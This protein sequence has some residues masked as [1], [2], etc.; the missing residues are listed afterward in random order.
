METKPK[1]KRIF[2]LLNLDGRNFDIVV[3]LERI[4]DQ[5]PRF[6]LVCRNG[7]LSDTQISVL[8]S[9][10]QSDLR[11]FLFVDGRDEDGLRIHSIENTVFHLEN[12]KFSLAQQV[13]GAPSTI[14]DLI[15]VYADV[16]TIINDESDNNP[17]KAHLKR[18]K[19][20]AQKIIGL[21]QVGSQKPEDIF[22]TFEK[23]CLQAYLEF[24][25]LKRGS[26]SSVP[27]KFE[28]NRPERRDRLAKLE[29]TYP[30]DKIV[31]ISQGMT[32][33][34]EKSVRE[35]FRKRLLTE[36]VASYV[37]EHCAPIWRNAV[38]EAKLLLT[39]T[40]FRVDGR[41]A[42][43]VDPRTFAGFLA[44]NGVSFEAT[45]I[46]KSSIPP[47]RG[48]NEWNC[49]FTAADGRKFTVPFFM[50]SDETPTAETVLETIQMD[51][52]SIAGRERDDWISELGYGDNIQNVRIGE[53]AFAAIQRNSAKLKELLGDEAYVA[54]MTDVGDEP[55]M[56]AS[57]FEQEAMAP[58]L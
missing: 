58:A 40:D 31:K 55:P 5:A 16:E 25:A 3:S 20:A 10:I 17:V 37:N 4:A 27:V 23:N 6:S 9:D 30:L 44:T 1:S 46:G 52:V 47:F 39:L 57:D 35:M 13:L 15:K 38:A 32:E 18:I 53:K 7:S 48:S 33:D 24:D 28:G 42:P 29:K 22:G 14:E 54:F 8:P 36:A 51:A 11:E 43:E 50:G 41:P 49:E 34:I 19:T 26:N 2:Q 12:A 56:S 21:L 45:R